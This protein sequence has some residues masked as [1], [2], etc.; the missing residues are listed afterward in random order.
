[1]D[2]QNSPKASVAA[3]L[4]AGRLFDRVYDEAIVPCSIE[5]GLEAQR[6]PSEFSEREMLIKVRDQIQR[7]HWI[8]ADLTAKNPNVLYQIGYAHAAE[9]SVSLIAQHGEDLPFPQSVYPT[10]VYAGNTSELLR[11]LRENLQQRRG[12]AFGGGS[13]NGPTAV[14]E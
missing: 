2:S 14:R 1:M 10:L 5:L 8:I 9:K 7:A 13:V 4:P 12:R 11:Q 6:V 3:L